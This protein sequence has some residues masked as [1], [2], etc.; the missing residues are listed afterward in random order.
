MRHA[1]P[2]LNALQRNLRRLARLVCRVFYE[3]VE[4]AGA[5][6]IPQEGAVALAL[7]KERR[8]FRENLR[9]LWSLAMGRGDMRQMLLEYRDQIDTRLAQLEVQIKRRRRETHPVQERPPGAP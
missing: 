8:R 2:P 7:V 3:Q 9:A 5:Q 1:V 6:H 4:V